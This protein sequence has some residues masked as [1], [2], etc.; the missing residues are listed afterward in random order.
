MVQAASDDRKLLAFHHQ[1]M[2]N[3]EWVICLAFRNMMT[4]K[5]QEQ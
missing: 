4:E 3:S 1:T 2:F 5:D